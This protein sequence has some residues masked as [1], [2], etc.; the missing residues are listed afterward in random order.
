M[1]IISKNM[2]WLEGVKLFDMAQIRGLTSKF[3]DPV[4]YVVSTYHERRGDELRAYVASGKQTEAQ[5]TKTLTA[6]G[7]KL[8]GDICEIVVPVPTD[9]IVLDKPAQIEAF[10]LLSLRTALKVEM[11]GIK[12]R[13]GV[14]ALAVVRKEFGIKARTAADALPKF[15]AL[16]KERGILK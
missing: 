8:F 11:A 3:K 7:R 9:S 6:G 15:E 5:A 10:R 1:A 12:V 14:S 16:L 4:I 13:R 2:E